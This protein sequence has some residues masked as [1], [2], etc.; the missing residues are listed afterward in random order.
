M[1][2]MN[3]PV[4]EADEGPNGPGSLGRLG[5][6]WSQEDPHIPTDESLETFLSWVESRGMELWPHQ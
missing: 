2:D 4:E 3:I 6:D 1:S 5:P